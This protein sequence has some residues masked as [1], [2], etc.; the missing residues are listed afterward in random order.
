MVADA[1]L[2]AGCQHIAFIAGEE[3][4]STNRDR[5]DGFVTQ[6][7]A[8][9]HTLDFRESAGDYRYDLGYKAAGRL[10][11]HPHPPDAIF[12]A[13][14]LIAMGALD[15]TRDKLGIQVPN[16]LSVI[17][18]D[19][20]PS[21][22]WPGYDLTTIQQPAEALVKNTVQILLNAIQNSPSETVEKVIAPILVKRSSARLMSA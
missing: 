16:D 10:F 14:D 8:R 18:F 11:Q 13:N 9:G 6:L 1:F 2:D 12:C 4:T 20:I 21:A 17:G 7:H 19:D 22:S 5:E 3:A 15:F